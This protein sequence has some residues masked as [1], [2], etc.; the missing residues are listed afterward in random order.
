MRMLTG[1]ETTALKVAD[2]LL[3]LRKVTQ[4]TPSATEDLYRQYAAS[5]DMGHR[6]KCK[7]VVGLSLYQQD[8]PLYRYLKD[9]L[10]MMATDANM[11]E[12]PAEYAAR[13]TDV[14]WPPISA[15][16]DSVKAGTK[17]IVRITGTPA[18]EF[19]V[20]FLDNQD[21]EFMKTLCAIHDFMFPK[22]GLMK[23]PAEY[24]LLLYIGLGE[25]GKIVQEWNYLAALQNVSLDTSARD[26]TSV[27]EIPVTFT[28]LDPFIKLPTTKIKKPNPRYEDNA[29]N[30]ARDNGIRTA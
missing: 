23:P 6:L 19:E 15:D 13:A 10:S 11:G 24:A 14:R 30:L 3:G 22:S 4:H 21:S 26:V 2:K 1:N 25:R 16:V 7:Y 28:Q 5:H 29:R 12:L 20:T 8:G 18:S 17:Q 27:M 9:A